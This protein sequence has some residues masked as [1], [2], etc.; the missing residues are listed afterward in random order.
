VKINSAMVHL[1]IVGTL[2][3]SG[4][5]LAAL[6]ENGSLHGEDRG[7]ERIYYRLHFR[8][9][10]RQHTRY[11][12]S[13]PRLVEQVRGELM[14]LQA[15]RHSRRRMRRLANEGRRVAREMKRQ[16]EPLLPG[17][18]RVFHGRTIRLRRPRGRDRV[19]GS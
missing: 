9:G 18:G 15:K 11:V 16:L 6:A 3:L 10:T 13:N 2:G 1:P 12:G 17:V 8:I 5:Q 14:L 19:V 7:L 4:E